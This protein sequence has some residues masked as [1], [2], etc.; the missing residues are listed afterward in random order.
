M[1]G[2][3]AAD[4]AV[5]GGSV[6]PVGG[7]AVGVVGWGVGKETEVGFFSLVGAADGAIPL[8]GA[9]AVGLGGID[10]AS[11]VATRGFKSSA[12]SR[13]FLKAPPALS[14]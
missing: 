4:G 12:S 13:D 1:G 8:V 5:V 2:V 6:A 9:T 3:E 11:A 10:A 7:L 14:S